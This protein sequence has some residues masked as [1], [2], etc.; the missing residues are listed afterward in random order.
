MPY[1]L[2]VVM[3]NGATGGGAPP[4]GGGAPPPGGGA[5]PPGGGTPPVGGQQSFWQRLLHQ[6]SAVTIISV[7]GTLLVSYF[8]NLSSYE[9]KVASL[10]KDDMAAATQTFSEASAALSAPLSLQERLVFGYFDAV[11]AKVEIDN[12]YITA[13]TR[14]LNGAY[15]DAYT[16]LRQ[17]IN[18][19]A[20]KVKLYLDWPSD[21]NRDLAM[22]ALLT[23]DPITDS[24]V[25]GTYKFD[26]DKNMPAFGI[27]KDTNKDLSK[28]VLTSKEGKKITFDWNSAKHEIFAIYYCFYVTHQNIELLR[29]WASAIKTDTSARAKFNEKKKDLEEQQTKQVLRLYTFMGLTMNDISQ[30]RKKYRPS[31]YLCSLP[32]VRQMI[33][34]SCMPV[35]TAGEA[36]LPTK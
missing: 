1:D 13:T 29:E 25:L 21:L 28:I 9:D 5:P 11:E 36:T 7:I 34:R 4:V 17:N 6:I 33:E 16:A 12:D 30:I 19:L 20:R 31:G 10:A 26:C 32:I 14:E 8:Q 23:S 18:V 27:D 15:K 3:S 22:N 35:R 24:S 2:E